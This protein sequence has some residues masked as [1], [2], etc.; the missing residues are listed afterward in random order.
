MRSA[1]DTI[2]GRLAPRFSDTEDECAERPGRNHA[3]SNHVSI[4]DRRRGVCVPANRKPALCRQAWSKHR[5]HYIECKYRPIGGEI[6]GFRLS[7]QH[8]NLPRRLDTSESGATANQHRLALWFCLSAKA[9]ASGVK[10]VV[11]T[12][13]AALAPRWCKTPYN[14]RTSRTPTG[15]PFR[16]LH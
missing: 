3:L 2:S 14:S 13:F 9:T 10:L 15:A 12:S 8:R 6:I 5:R 16:R 1:A 4:H 7:M 11:A